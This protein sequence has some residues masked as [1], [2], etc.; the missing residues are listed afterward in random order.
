MMPPIETLLARLPDAKKSGSG[1]RARC[2]AHDDR[3]ASLSLSTGADGRVLLHCHAGCDTAAVLA[4]VGLKLADLFP[5]KTG[6]AP[7]RNGKPIGAARTFA[8]AEDAVA[9]LT[10]WFGRTPDHTWEYRNE[11]GDLVGLTLRWNVLNGKKIYP[12]ARHGDSWRIAAMASPRVLY[13]LP[14][15]IKSDPSQLVVICEGELATAAAASLGFIATCSAGGADAA[16]KSDWSPLRDRDVIVLPDHDEAGERYAQDVARLVTAAG[17]KSV[18]ILRLADHAPDLPPRGD[19][20]DVLASENWCGLPLGDTAEPADLAA[21]IKAL[22]QTIEPWRPDEADDPVCHLYHPFPV[23]ALPELLRQFVDA[24]AQAIGCDVS[25]LALP[26]LTA[27]AATIGNTRRL[28][29]KRGWCA[30]PIL[31]TALVGES[32]SAKTAALQLVLKPIRER[33]RKALERH[34]EAMK[35]YRADRTRWERDMT[36]WKKRGSG[37]PPAEPEEPRPE[38]HIVSDTTVEALA[39]ILL[40]NPRGLLLA[41]DELAGWI[42]SF[43][44]YANKGRVGADMAF[45]LSAHNAEPA[46][47]DRK[48]SG[49]VF[50]PSAAV[51]VVGGVQPA[52]LRRALGREHRENGLLARLLLAYPPRRPKRW[53]EADIDPSAEAELARLFDRLYELQ[54]TVGDDGEP[55]P[56]LVHLSDEA[57]AA[58]VAYYNEHN[59]EQAEEVGDLASALAKL[60]EAAARLALVIHYVRWAAGE[61]ADETRLDATSMNAGIVL[62]NWFKHETR[63]IYAMLDE[64]DAE[65]DRRRL[66]EWVARRGGTTTIRETQQSCRWLK[67]PGAAA[68]ALEGLVQA[69][70]GNWQDSS[71]T[72]KGGRPTRVFVL[73]QRVNMSTKPPGEPAPCLRNLENP[74]ENRGFVDVDTVDGPPSGGCVDA[75]VDNPPPADVPG[76]GGGAEAP[77]SGTSAT[78]PAAQGG[79]PESDGS[80]G[81]FVVSLADP[82]PQPAEPPVTG[83]PGPASPPP[84]VRQPGLE[85]AIVWLKT[86]LEAGPQP[87]EE[88][89]HWWTLRG[90]DRQ[91]LYQAAVKLGV[92]TRQGPPGQGL[93]WQLPS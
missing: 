23:N 51:C 32:G 93:F 66:L 60:E 80:E 59:R 15:L 58:W 41:R 3:V 86:S 76:G 10:R 61:V 54:P 52:I 83:A 72:T 16:H 42:G 9:A 92:D 65:R 69:G 53:S 34:A 79:P 17:A 4:A 75:A 38:R 31:W 68:A 22:A 26:L 56:V 2:P 64:S 36:T 84:T 71:S 57:K 13:Q 21:K 8:T 50:I 19:L 74:R 43:D 89:A 40:N 46:I 90:H 14:Q 70:L 62:A 11:R 91:L 85:H 6:S 1:W 88:L 63:R 18:R 67:E 33:Q 73:R 82:A 5:A 35:Q 27:I 55:R 87:I 37:L 39:P 30:P 45:W 24:G 25:Y 44:R 77:L 28:K 81:A 29:L 7:A 48:T 12:V 20:A 78:T 47:V 49:T